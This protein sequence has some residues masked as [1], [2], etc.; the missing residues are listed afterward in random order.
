MGAVGAKPASG[1]PLIAWHAAWWA[2]DPAWAN[3]GDGN[4]VGSWRDFSGNGRD[5]SQA[6]A[7]NKPTFHSSTAALNGKAS[8]EF[9]GVNDRMVTGASWSVAQPFSYV[10]LARF[11]S[12][13]SGQRG[14]LDGP[15]SSYPAALFTDTSTGTLNLYAGGGA[16]WKGPAIAAGAHAVRSTMN[17]GSSAV[18]V[19]ASGPGSIVGGGPGSAGSGGLTLGSVRDG[20]GYSNVAV[21]FAAVFA[22]NVTTAPNWP[23]FKAWVSSYYGLTLA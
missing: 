4:A 19:D 7:A 20:S 15:S 10:L 8:I 5:V 16:Y 6:T 17:G 1:P 22:G 3:P 13:G 11:V 23:A 12:V 21:A 18:F 14:V 2:D 9:D